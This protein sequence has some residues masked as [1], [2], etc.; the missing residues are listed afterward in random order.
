MRLNCIEERYARGSDGW[1]DGEEK[2]RGEQG[3]ERPRVRTT[4]A[5]WAQ[6]A[7]GSTV[8]A[9]RVSCGMGE[10]GYAMLG[11]RRVGR[12]QERREEVEAGAL[13]CGA[14]AAVVGR[15]RLGAMLAWRR[16]QAATLGQTRLCA[17]ARGGRGGGGLRG[18]AKRA[19]PRG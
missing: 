11:A 19:G 1:F 8:G 7:A 15:A 17:R 2:Q 12:L 3:H 18:C 16:C 10:R 6:L 14:Q 4:C 5:T 9:R 13:G